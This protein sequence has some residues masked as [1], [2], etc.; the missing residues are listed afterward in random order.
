VEMGIV[1]G[2]VVEGMLYDE[3]RKF[4]EGLEKEG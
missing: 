2:A 4:K 1:F 3:P